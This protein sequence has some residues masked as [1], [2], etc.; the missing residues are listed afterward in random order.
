MPSLNS[1][2]FLSIISI[3]IIME[4]FVTEVRDNP[5]SAALGLGAVVAMMAAGYF[6][7][8]LNKCGLFMPITFVEHTTPEHSK[9]VAKGYK[10]SF[11]D[12]PG[13]YEGI[14]KLFKDAKLLTDENAC[15]FF[16]TIHLIGI[17][18]ENPKEVGEHNTR[19]A[20]GMISRGDDPLIASAE[21]LLCENGY[22]VASLPKQRSFMTIFPMN[23]YLSIMIGVRRVYPSAFKYAET[24]YGSTKKSK[25]NYEIGRCGV[26]E[27]HFVLEDPTDE[28]K[29]F[30]KEF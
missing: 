11:K 1:N 25:F 10:T 19:F 13:I 4:S 2:N 6:I 3:A 27:F 22:Q 14:F 30:V 21:K 29:A 24:V 26:M 23:G 9:I 8:Y 28:I 15:S 16:Q 20:I 5:T 7:N 17:Y 12:I 18:F